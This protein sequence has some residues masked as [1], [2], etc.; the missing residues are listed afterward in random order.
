MTP[1]FVMARR[2]SRPSASSPQLK[3]VDARQ[4]EGALRTV[5]RIERLLRY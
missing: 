5:I 4:R 1:K 2:L 3:D